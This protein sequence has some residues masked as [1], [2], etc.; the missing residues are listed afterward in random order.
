MDTCMQTFSDI[1]YHIQITLVGVTKKVIF[2]FKVSNLTINIDILESECSHFIAH[3]QYTDKI[4][5]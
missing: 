5:R 3:E 2:I 4:M 1:L